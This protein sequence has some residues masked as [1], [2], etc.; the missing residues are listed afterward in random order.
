[1]CY[2]DNM[3]DANN[4]LNHK[5]EGM[6]LC[7][8]DNMHDSNKTLNHMKEGMLLKQLTPQPITSMAR[9]SLDVI[10]TGS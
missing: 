10:N 4:T 5:K 9:H 6:L 7:Y 1:M 2:E 3:H 8:E